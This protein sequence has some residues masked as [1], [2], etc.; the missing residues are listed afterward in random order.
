MES[1]SD[2]DQEKSLHAKIKDMQ[3]NV[4]DDRQR[5]AN[6]NQQRDQLEPEL[7]QLETKTLPRIQSK[8]GKL[9]SEIQ[10]LDCNG[11]HKKKGRLEEQYE[12]LRKQET[13]LLEQ[14]RALREQLDSVRA[15][16]NALIKKMHADVATVNRIAADINQQEDAAFQQARSAFQQA[17]ERMPASAPENIASFYNAGRTLLLEMDKEYQRAARSGENSFHLHAHTELLKDA[18]NL[19]LQPRNESSHQRIHQ[20]ADKYTKD[21]FSVG[22]AVLGA[23]LAFLGVAAMI[24]GVVFALPTG[25]L[26]L[27][28]AGA[29]YLMFGAG[30]QLMEK[31][32]A[33][34]VN[35]AAHHFALSGASA[36]ETA[37]QIQEEEAKRGS[38]MLSGA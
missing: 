29:G 38:L 25:S 7:R 26:S 31:S 10:V 5:L 17:L 1:R 11:Q 35:A 36:P 37:G 23:T 14:R 28:G 30:L 19:L 9:L 12:T 18:K 27:F 8:M 33:S 16:R 3:R 2:V 4:K 34:K 6:F 15:E 21:K 13:I 32:A 22:R 20:I 24:A